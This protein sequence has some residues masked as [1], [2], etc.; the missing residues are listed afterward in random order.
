MP[1]SY[2]CV[3]ATAF[4]SPDVLKVVEC[5]LKEPT[6]GRVRLKVLAAS[7]SRPDITVRMG[8]SLYAGTPLGQKIPFV[9]GYSI[10]GEVDAIGDGVEQVKFGDRYA[11]LTV[12][13]GYSEFVTLEQKRLIPFPDQLDPVHTVPLILNYIVAYQAMHR[14]AQVQSG[15]SALIIGASG[16][17]GTALLQL[18][19]LMDMQMYA[20]ASSSKHAFL[21]DMGAVP[22][23]YH[24]P[25][26]LA[27]IRAAQPDG[28]MYIFDGMMTRQYLADGLSLLKKGGVYVGYGEPADFGTLFAFL[29]KMIVVNLLPNRKT[30]KLYGTSKY[31][32]NQKPFL[33]DWAVLFDLLAQGK[34]NP[35]IYAKFPLLEAA[36]AN[37]LLESGQVIGN[38][39]LE[40]QHTLD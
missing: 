4:G 36:E 6:K 10:I 17:I 24:Q 26:Y 23:D 5:D 22:I 29:R 9:P 39:V 7:V 28:I 14:A 2:H 11:A 19:K 21:A 15:E 33:E 25:D 8:T 27:Q 13:G 30:V 38:I 35:I 3:Q 40:I 34:I 37:R 12:V 1:N 20:L 31:T 18:G 16:G 32:F